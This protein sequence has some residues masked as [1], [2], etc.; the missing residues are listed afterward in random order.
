[1][2]QKEYIFQG[3]DTPFHRYTYFRAFLT[4]VDG[5]HASEGPSVLP[6]EMTNIPV[7]VES[8]IY[9]YLTS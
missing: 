1:M 4:F 2:K 3:Y 8:V 5:A 6:E 7:R 9:Y